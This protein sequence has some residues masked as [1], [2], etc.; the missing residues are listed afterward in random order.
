MASLQK[1]QVAKKDSTNTLFR[2]KQ[3]F[4]TNA[5][6]FTMQKKASTGDAFLE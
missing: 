2:Y 5:R 1:P 4:L 3:T 6:F